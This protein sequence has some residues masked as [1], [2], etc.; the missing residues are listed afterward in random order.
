[1]TN[2]KEGHTLTVDQ[3]FHQF[4]LATWI[5]SGRGFIENDDVRVVQENASKGQPLLFAARQGLIPRTFLVEPYREMVQPYA[6]ECLLYLIQR[7]T[8]WRIGITSRAAQTSD[9][10]VRTLRQQ[11]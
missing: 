1:M 5:Q 4:L 7:S 11:T 8:V 9:W 6:F 10:N 2:A 3:Q